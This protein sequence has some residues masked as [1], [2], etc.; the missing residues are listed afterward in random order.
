MACRVTETALEASGL[1]KTI[2]APISDNTAIEAAS[3]RIVH[4]QKAIVKVLFSPRLPAMSSD[5]LGPN[6]DPSLCRLS[7]IL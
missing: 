2:R 6:P 1:L 4:V 5:L 7:Q 3:E